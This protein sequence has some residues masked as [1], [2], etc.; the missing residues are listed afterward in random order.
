MGVR[1][2]LLAIRSLERAQFVRL[3]FAGVSR[4][5]FVDEKIPDF[6]PA[7]AGVEGFVWGVA[8]PAKLRIGLGG[9]GAVAIADDLEDAF[10]LIDLLAQHRAEI[11]GLGA[12]EIL[13]EWLRT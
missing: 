12:E 6:L 2:Q 9:L 7:L 4:G 3:G 8:D 5:S 1:S 11:A 10:A 13:P